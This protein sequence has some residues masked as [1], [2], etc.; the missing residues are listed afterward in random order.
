MTTWLELE[1]TVLNERCQAQR[2]KQPA[3][4]ITKSEKTDLTEVESRMVD[5]EGWY[6]REGAGKG[7]SDGY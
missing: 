7:L 4:A 2:I 6:Q 1:I 3:I 5:T